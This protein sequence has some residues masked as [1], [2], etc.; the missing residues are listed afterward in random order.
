MIR[1]ALVNPQGQVD[2]FADGN[3]DPAVQTKAGWRWLPVVLVDALPPHDIKTQRLVGPTY[4]VEKGVVRQSWSIRAK[5]VE[6]IAAGRDMAVH[7]LGDA[8]LLP[9]ILNLHNRLR[10]L[11]GQAPHTLA[12]VET[13]IKE[14]A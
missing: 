12:Q 14:M 11:E 5:T 7:R 2:R 6:E 4:T 8:G 3:I 13:A 9:I 10:A 1:Y